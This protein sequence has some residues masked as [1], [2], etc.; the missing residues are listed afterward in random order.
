MAKK[1]ALYK[2][3]GEIIKILNFVHKN[4]KNLP[5]QN[6]REKIFAKIHKKSAVYKSRGEIFQNTL[7][8][9]RFK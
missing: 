2:S 4:R 7:V 1:S 8:E 5:I 3:E 9:M 6:S